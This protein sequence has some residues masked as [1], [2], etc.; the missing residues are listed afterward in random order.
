MDPC[1]KVGGDLLNMKLLFFSSDESEI[2]LASKECVDA[3]IPCEVRSG[4]MPEGVSSKPPQTEL[5]IQNDCDSHRALMLCVTL[6]VG[7]SRRPV[8]AALVEA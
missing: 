7:F 6:G 1:G 4:P 5:W 3:G 8:K 2:E